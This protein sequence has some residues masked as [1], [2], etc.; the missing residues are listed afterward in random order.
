VASGDGQKDA[1]RVHGLEGRPAL[2]LATRHGIKIITVREKQWREAYIRRMTPTEAA[3][4]AASDYEANNRPIDR[5][6][7]RKR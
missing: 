5:A 7:R 4:R 6:G 2:E 3:D 1:Q